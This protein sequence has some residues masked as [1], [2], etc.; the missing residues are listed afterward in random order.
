M[1]MLTHFLGI[2]AVIACVI[3]GTLLPF[4]PGRYDGLA[5]PL[6]GMCQIFG[7]VELL[8]VPIGALWVASGHWNP[9]AGKQYGIA[10]AALIT[11]SVV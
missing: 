10:I 5:A 9:I 2:T 3:L 6:S 7:M 4:L 1:F 11:S 8:L